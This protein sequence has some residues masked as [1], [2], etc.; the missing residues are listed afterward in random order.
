[1][2]YPRAISARYDPVVKPLISCCVNTSRGDIPVSALSSQGL[3]TLHVGTDRLGIDELASFDV[4]AHHVRA[5]RIAVGVKAELAGD[6]LKILR[7]THSL[8]DSR[9]VLFASPFDGVE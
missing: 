4:P 3:F 2:V 8:Q 9:A 6:P 5:V 1:M 7:L